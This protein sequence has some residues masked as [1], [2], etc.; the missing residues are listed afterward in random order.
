MNGKI[1]LKKLKEMGVTQTQVAEWLG[2][3]KQSVSALKH[4]ET[5]R[6]STIETIAK[7]LGIS[8]AEL[9]EDEDTEARNAELRNL[10]QEVAMLKEELKRKDQTIERLIGII[11]Q[12]R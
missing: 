3:T 9:F 8:V 5:V 10:R 4:T 2:V 7:A 6:T 12:S 1:F 11:E